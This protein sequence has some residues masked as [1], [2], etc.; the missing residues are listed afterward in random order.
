MSRLYLFCDIG[1]SGFHITVA[2]WLNWFDCV[3]EIGAL[4][5]ARQDLV[6]GDW[7]GR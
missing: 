7:Y 3:T 1:S 5:N 4:R 2:R 6:T